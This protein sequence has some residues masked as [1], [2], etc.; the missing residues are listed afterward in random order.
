[1]RDR[2]RGGRRILLF[3][4]VLLARLAPA[5]AAEIIVRGRVL[6]Q[7]GRPL[8]GATIELAPL[9]THYEATLAAWRGE[10]DREPAARVLT[11]D[12]RRVRAARSRAR[13]LEDGGPRRGVGRGRVSPGAAARRVDAGRS[14]SGRGCGAGGWRAQGSRA[15]RLVKTST[16]AAA[17]GGASRAGARAAIDAVA[18][19]GDAAC[20]WSRTTARAIAGALVCDVE[21]GVPL[22]LTDAGRHRA[23]RR[24]QGRAAHRGRRAGARR[25]G[26]PPRRGR[27]QDRRR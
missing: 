13:F 11:D 8:R 12:G 25:K 19:P 24:R 3:A 27:P 9:L 17:A 4:L 14:A 22:G 18:S 10:P 7:S 5:G 23:G 15:H 2:R 26:G 20:A 6:D 21:L 16:K 1:M